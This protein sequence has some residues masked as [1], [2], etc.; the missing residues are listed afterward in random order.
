M[1]LVN[2]FLLGQS[3]TVG[4]TKFAAE[5]CPPSPLRERHAPIA[6]LAA[7]VHLVLPGI[8]ARLAPCRHPKY[9]TIAFDAPRGPVVISN[10]L[11]N[12]L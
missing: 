10:V 9:L 6:I 12:A 8:M 3:A 5:S 7:P 11:E 1:T 2:R 4:G